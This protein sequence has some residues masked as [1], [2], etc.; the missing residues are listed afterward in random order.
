MGEA[1][2]RNLLWIALGFPMLME[3]MCVKKKKKQ[4]GLQLMS[5]MYWVQNKL[6]SVD[7][8]CVMLFDCQTIL[9]PPSAGDKKKKKEEDKLHLL[10]SNAY[11][12]SQV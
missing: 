12:R 9:P 4:H 7:S 3:R 2:M 6:S 10:Y 5:L 1:I 11:N 8:I